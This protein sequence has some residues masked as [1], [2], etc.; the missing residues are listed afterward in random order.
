MP[1]VR[2]GRAR[3]AGE[4][5]QRQAVIAGDWK[6]ILDGEGVELYRLSDDPGELNDLS[7][8]DTARVAE[9]AALIRQWDLDTT[10]ISTDEATLSEDDIDA[11]NALGYIE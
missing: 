7:K 8:T 10:R 5:P 11:L 1:K 3:S 2:G 9:L 6:L 4:G